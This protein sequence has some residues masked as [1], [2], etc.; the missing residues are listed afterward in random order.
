MH[1]SRQRSSHFSQP[2][3]S[4]VQ[5]ATDNLGRRHRPDYW[6]LVMTAM[7]LV[8]GLVVVYSISPGLAASQKIS[9]NYFITK[10]LIDVGLGVSAFWLAAHIPLKAWRRLAIPLL[11]TAVIGSIIVMLT[12]VNE[13]YP[14]HRWIRVGSYSMQIAELI[15]LALIVWLAGWLSYKWRSGKLADFNSTTK[16]LL[17]L[18]LA[19]SVVVA[20]LQSDL[21]SAFVILAIVGLM[22]F[23]IGAPLKKLMLASVVVLCLLSLGIASSDYRRQRLTTFLHPGANCQNSGYHACQALIAVGSGGLFGLGLGYSVQAYG[24][25]P[26]ASNDSIF[27]VMAE[28]F[29]FIGSVAMVSAY[30]VFIFRI[31]RI[32]ERTTEQFSRLIAVGVLAWLSTQA[33]I[34]IGAMIGLLPLKG[35]TLPL[36]S[37]GGTSLIF[38]TAALGLVFQISR[39]TSYNVVEPRSDYQPPSGAGDSIERRRV[40]RSPNSHLVARPRA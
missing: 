19:V 10:Q 11:V 39:Y 14:A 34:N 1:K 17:G 33:I 3:R 22:V 27:A 21:G 37:Q 23:M 20:K 29:G 38:M 9:Q 25:L 35:I 15:K 12:P 36:I 13:L 8:V 31:K 30:G 5:A 28:K 16:W 40:G 6:L 4:G 24:Y 32:I 7:M 26:E 2:R 18:L